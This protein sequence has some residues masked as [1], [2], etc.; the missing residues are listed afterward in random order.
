[1]ERIS[2][3]RPITEI[4]GAIIVSST[5]RRPKYTVNLRGRPW[6]YNRIGAR[7]A[8]VRLLRKIVPSSAA[9]LSIG[10]SIGI[11]ENWNRRSTIQPAYSWPTIHR[12]QFCI[13]ENGR[14]QRRRT[15][16]EDVD[17]EEKR[18]D[19]WSTAKRSSQSAVDFLVHRPNFEAG[20]GNLTQTWPLVERRP[21][22]LPERRFLVAL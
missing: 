9:F 16:Q 5:R 14:G 22:G 18:R 6:Q 7:G 2:L 12:P 10:R 4:A 1:M 13:D 11:P 8:G 21:V 17:E 19:G 20:A 15:N 3:A